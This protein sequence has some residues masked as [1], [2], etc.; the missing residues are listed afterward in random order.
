MKKL[1]LLLCFLIVPGSVFADCTVTMTPVNILQGQDTTVTYTVNYPEVT[2]G[3]NGLFIQN[4]KYDH[5]G[6]G[7]VQGISATSDKTWDTINCTDTWAEW[8]RRCSFDLDGANY[9]HFPI[10]FNVTYHAYNLGTEQNAYIRF[11]DENG[12]SNNSCSYTYP[13]LNSVSTL[14]AYSPDTTVM[15]AGTGLLGSLVSGYLGIIPVGLGITGGLMATLFGVSKLF[16]WVR[17]NLHG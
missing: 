1:I 12:N 14:T 16:G 13:V 17:G 10:V 11:W 6:S 8:N 3:I 9:N 4:D 2:E 5:P 15:Q 7:I